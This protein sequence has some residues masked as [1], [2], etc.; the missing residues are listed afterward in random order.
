M[1][2]GNSRPSCEECAQEILNTGKVEYHCATNGL[3]F[4]S[5]CFVR[6]NRERVEY[7]GKCARHYCK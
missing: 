7:V 1:E 5:E 3:T 2:S 4:M 6:C